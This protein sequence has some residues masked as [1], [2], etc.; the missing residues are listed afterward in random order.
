MT[1]LDDISHYLGMKVDYV[2]GGKITLCQSTY[3]KKV[4]DQFKMTGCN[5]AIICM[6]PW[7]ANSLIPYHGNAD[8]ASIK[9]Y[10]SAIGSLMWLAVYTR[11]D[12]AYSV[13]VLSRYCRN[14]GPT[15]WNLLVQVFRYLSATLGLRIIFNA[16]WENDLVGYTDSDYAG[17]VDGRKSTSGCIFMLSGGFLSHQSKLQSTF[18]LSSTEAEYMATTE[19]GKEA[20]WISWFLTSLRY[21]LPNPP[22]DLRTDHK[23]TISLTENPEF[24][25]KT[26]H[27]EVRWHLIREKSRAERVCH[28][29]DL[30]QGNASRRTY[31]GAQP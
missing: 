1:D 23:G 21:Q 7:V 26:K 13:G 6:N 3:L 25:R 5:P 24:H 4:L 30:S 27:I 10:Q 8:K 17:L 22:I 20:L 2:V 16:N 19:A 29:V 14:P 31:K 9:W 11:P 18:A 28:F 15:Y 12:I